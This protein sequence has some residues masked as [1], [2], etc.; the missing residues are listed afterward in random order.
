MLSGS[1]PA[2]LRTIP[3]GGLVIQVIEHHEAMLLLIRNGKNGSA[4]ALARSIFK[5]MFRG[6]R[7]QLCATDAQLQYFE[8][9][10]EL[11][12]DASGKQM[13]MAKM[14][15]SVR[16]RVGSFQNPPESYL[17]KSFFLKSRES[18]F[19]AFH[20]HL[21]L[22]HNFSSAMRFACCSSIG[23]FLFL[24]RVAHATLLGPRQ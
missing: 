4:F 9:N 10:D 15:I 23:L 16:S 21:F 24:L 20:R 18:G 14:A 8:Q 2:D 5:S 1:H 3:V 22:E 7:F 11:P 6:M 19:L 13:N 12:P 17:R